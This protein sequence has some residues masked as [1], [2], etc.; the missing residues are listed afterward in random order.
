MSFTRRRRDRRMPAGARQLRAGDLGERAAAAQPPSECPEL[1]LL[2]TSC[3]ALHVRAE[4]LPTRPTDGPAAGRLCPGDR[5]TTASP[6]PSSRSSTGRASPARDSRL[7]DDNAAAVAYSAFGSTACRSPSSCGCSFL[8]LFSPEALRD[9]SRGPAGDS[10]EAAPATSRRASRRCAAAIDWSYQ[11][12]PPRAAAVRAA[13]GVRRREVTAIEAV[14]GDVGDRSTASRSTCST[15]SRAGREEPAPAGGRA[16]APSRGWRC[17]RRSTSPPPTAWTS[18]PDLAVRGA[19][20]AC[21]ALHGPGPVAARGPRGARARVAL[22]RWATTSRTS[23]SR[24]RTGSRRRPDQLNKLAKALLDP[25]RGPRL[26]PGR[27]PAGDRDARRPGH[28]AVLP[29]RAGPGDR[30]ATMPPGRC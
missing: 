9:T 6:R 5:P 2:V 21:H 24:G 3:E 16:G 18:D 10:S 7:T 27:G 8:R 19:L 17:S 28:G 23:A 20:G 26:V 30:A 15:G 29:G 4:D 14:V 22:K 12:L 11:L 1:T 25:G 13:G